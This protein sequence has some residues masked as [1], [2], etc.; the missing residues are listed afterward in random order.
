MFVFT[1][2]CDAC[3]FRGN[4]LCGRIGYYVFPDGIRMPASTSPAWCRQCQTI[5]NAETLPTADGVLEEIAR[6]RNNQT[7]ELDVELAEILSQTLAEFV[8]SRLARFT[9]LDSRFRDRQSN[10]RCIDCGSSDFAYLRDNG[11]DPLPQELLHEGCRG[12]LRLVETLHASPATYFTLDR[13]GNRVAAD[14]AR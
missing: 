8:S 3:S 1:Y 5:T 11:R 2:E 4:A 10:N 7:N 9:E 12:T 14:N 13:E 6:L